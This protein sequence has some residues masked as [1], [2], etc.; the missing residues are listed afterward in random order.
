MSNCSIHGLEKGAV[1]NALQ[2]DQMLARS[3]TE[4]LK[5]RAT[6]FSDCRISQPEPPRRYSICNFPGSFDMLCRARLV[7]ESWV[8][9]GVCLSSTILTSQA[10]KSSTQVKH[11]TIANRLPLTP[12]RKVWQFSRIA[13]QVHHIHNVYLYDSSLVHT[14][15]FGH[16]PS[17]PEKK[18][19]LSYRAFFIARFLTVFDV[20]IALLLRRLF[21]SGSFAVLSL[22]IGLRLLLASASFGVQ[23]ESIGWSLLIGLFFCADKNKMISCFVLLI[24]PLLRPPKSD[25]PLPIF[26]RFILQG[27]HNA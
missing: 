16:R 15:S 1:Q 24:S 6:G 7:D 12:I 26:I 2:N 14:C 22:S 18:K 23:F 5:V 25:K 17:C 20:K 21:S 27:L 3:C 10:L 8:I 19:A 13:L 4:N 11:S 9:R